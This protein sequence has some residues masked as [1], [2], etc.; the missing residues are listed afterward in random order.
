MIRLKNGSDGFEFDAYHVPPGDARRGGLVLVQEIFGLSDGIKTLADGFAHDGYEVIAP[1]LFDRVEP[2]FLADPADPDDVARAR[3]A[4]SRT[5]WD[6]TMGDVQ[7]AIDALAPPVFITGFCWGGSVSWLAACRATGLAASSGFYGR[8]IV[9]FLDDAPK[10]PV[11]LHYGRTDHSIPLTD[12]EKV[13]AAHPEVPV[14]L[15]DAGHGF[16]SKE[17]KDYAAD[18]ASLARLRTLQLFH[19]SGGQKG[20]MGG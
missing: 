1:A 3:A 13:E 5:D 19:R 18:A 20:E 10:C 2:G 16:M 11:I 14:W 7:A 17:R 15:Y 8:Q 6:K 4:S 9:N 12:V